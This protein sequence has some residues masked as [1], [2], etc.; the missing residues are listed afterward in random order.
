MLHLLVYGL[1]VYKTLYAI[2]GEETLLIE[3]KL[4]TNDENMS[5]IHTF[6]NDYYSKILD[7]SLSYTY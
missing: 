2:K 1:G 4:E 7:K 6:S 5:P 3:N